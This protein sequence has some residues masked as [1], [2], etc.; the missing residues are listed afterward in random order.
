MAQQELPP[1]KQKTSKRISWI[2]WIVGFVVLFAILTFTVAA[3]LILRNQGTTEGTATLTILSIIVG[4]VIAL[5]GLL[6]TFLQWFHSR[7]P[8]IFEP[9]HLSP[10]STQLKPIPAHSSPSLPSPQSPQHSEAV[11]TSVVDVIPAFKSDSYIS[12]LTKDTDVSLPSYTHH[13]DWGEA[14]SVDQFY[15]RES[16]SA[17]LRQWIVDARCQIVAIT[18]LGGIGKTSLMASLTKE[19]KFEFEFVYWRSLQNAPSSK[20]IMNNCIKFLSRQQQIDLPEDLDGQITLL[21]QYLREHRCLIVLDNFETVLQAGTHAGQYRDDYEGY[22]KLL[23][24]LGETKHQSCLVLTS[25]EKPKEIAWIEGDTSLVRSSQLKGLTLI[26]GKEILKVKGLQG[27]E[28]TWKALIDFYAGNPLALK[29]VSQSIREV[30]D[31]NIASFLKTDEPVSSDVSDVL[32]QQFHRL[33]TLEKDVMYWLATER[34]AVS[35][36]DVRDNLVHFTSRR[37]L[38]AALKSLRQRSMIETSSIERFIL[39]PVIMEYVTD[40]FVQQIFE[41]INTETIDLLISHSLMKAQTKDY[42]RN[43]QILCILIPLLERLIAVFGKEES[44]KKL[45]SILTALHT[46][47]PQIPGYAAGN[48]INL[49]VQLKSDLQGYDFSYLRVRQAYLQNIALPD[50]NFT[51]AD[52]SQSV[53]TETFGSILAVAFSP[54]GV[55][56]AAATGDGDIRLW[57][58]ESGKP[59]MTM[60]GHKD[61]VWSIAFSPNGQL[62]ASGGED[63]TIRL[64]E[65]STGRE[66]KVLQGHRGWIR[67]V[68]FSPNGQLLASAGED[69]R[70]RLWEI[71]TGKLLNTMD[72]YPGWIRS[73]TFSP[74][75]QLLASAGENQAVWL[76]QVNTCTCLKIFQSHTIKVRS[77]AF[78]PDG[79]VL[80][81]GGPASHDEENICFWEIATGR[82]YAPLKGPNKPTWSVAFSFDGKFLATSSDD[83]C[84]RLWDRSTGECLYTL[85]GHQNIIRSVSFSPDGRFLA[86][87]CEDETVRLWDTTTGK[88]QKTLQGHSR[89]TWSIAFSPD[90]KTLASGD[91]DHAVRLWDVHSARVFSK[92]QGHIFRVGSVAF[93]PGGQLLASGSEDQTVRLWDIKTGKCLK[94]LQGHTHKVRSV[95]FSS[96][97]NILASGGEDHLVRLWNVRTGREIQCLSGHTNIVWSVAFSPIQHVVAS[98]SADQTVRLWDAHTGLE[99]NVLRGHT[100]SIWST[101]FT[102]EGDVIASSSAD[103]TVRLWDVSTGQHLKT[104]EGHTHRVRSI[105]FSPNGELIASGSEDQTVRLWDVHSGKCLRILNCMPNQ[106]RSLAFNPKGQFLAYSTSEGPIE[107]FDATTGKYLKTLESDR[108]YEGMNI[109]G[110]RGLTEAQIATLKALGAFEKEN[111]MES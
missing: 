105:A 75:G 90:G 91:E 46:I 54:D 41:E 74:D 6:F 72:G 48:V 24:R 30:F 19:I 34:E 93:S 109:T 56:L 100:G 110:S 52:L 49:L 102:P 4:I 20:S 50:V 64:W 68:A 97:S 16:E 87:G 29:L 38:L 35:L 40:N 25:R 57:E 92:L 1:E 73:I 53:F 82:E 37:E 14:P 66:T 85:Q 106:L 17:E 26:D 10:S 79:E 28:S 77:L 98:G 62:L 22:G 65:V 18:G 9:P 88:C 60:H 78:S 3:L 23:Q 43:S 2:P 70:I 44:Q 58:A 61:W 12:N 51:G 107:F 103:S 13:E 7:P 80:V 81:S 31:G 45:K 84:V 101:A 104:L 89:S 5:L 15:G 32:S 27:G 67:S 39:Q 55:L 11:S 86:S 71:S 42:I 36:D 83:Y 69:Q 99:L 47:P 8:D 95:A 59:I 33:S 63:Q 21:I 96:D 108:L 94:I 111:N 76:W